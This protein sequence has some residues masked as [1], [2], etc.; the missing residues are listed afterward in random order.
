MNFHTS[1]LVDYES[2]TYM[3]THIHI[4]LYVYTHT[5]THTHTCLGTQKNVFTK[6]RW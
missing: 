1:A 5:H 4:Y 6:A 2:H 3:H